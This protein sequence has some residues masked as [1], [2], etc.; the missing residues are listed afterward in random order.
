[1]KRTRTSTLSFSESEDSDGSTRSSF[2]RHKYSEP[3]T[4]SDDIGGFPIKVFV[5]QAKVSPEEISELISMVEKQ[6][7]M[8]MLELCSI[9]A[10]ADVIVTGIQMKK[11]LERHIPWQLARRRAIVNPQWIR[12]SVEKEQIMPCGDY[13]ALQELHAETAHNCPNPKGCDECRGTSG[14]DAEVAPSSL[15]HKA[16]YACQRASPLVCANQSLAEEIDILRRAREL[17]GDAVG[18]LAYERAVAVIKAYP[19]VISPSRLESDLARISGI[20]TKLQVKIAE[21]L[22]KGQISEA[23]EILASPRFR[24]LSEFNTIYGIGPV[25]ARQLYDNGMSTLEHLDSYYGIRAHNP[26][27]EEQADPNIIESRWLSIKGMPEVTIQVGL[28]LRR[29]LSQ[30]IP[31]EEVCDMHAIV[32]KGLESLQH[33]CVSTIVGGYRR[34]KEESNDVD[35]VISHQDWR[36]GGEKIKGLC[37]KLVKHLYDE[38]LVTHVMHLSSFRPHNAL[39]TGH[40]DSLEKALTIFRLPEADGKSRIHRR[41]DLIFAS[42]EAYWTAVTG[43][44]GSRMFERDLRLWAKDEKGYKFDSTGITRRH[45]SRLFYP[46][47]EQEVFEILGLEWVDPTLRNTGV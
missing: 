5:V 31:R 7:N 42:P 23:R 46:K 34:G 33:G 45:D 22:K 1:M 14:P 47:S 4:E 16:R 30:K 28:A 21:Y 41:L 18:T 12:D 3:D 44:T 29:D 15:S 36:G 25:T 20:G 11:R 6:K 37:T 35:I 17:E 10:E 43:W 27:I 19:H 32:M 40:W 26:A 9:P 39:R 2:K 24:S 13:A 38:G 8:R